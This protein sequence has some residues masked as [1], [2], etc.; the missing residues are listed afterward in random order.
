MRKL[1]PRTAELARILPTLQTSQA[2]NLVKETK[3]GRTWVSRCEVD[4]S[5]KALVSYEEFNHG[6]GCWEVVATS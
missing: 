3:K 5:G 2:D 1:S 4:E 6:K